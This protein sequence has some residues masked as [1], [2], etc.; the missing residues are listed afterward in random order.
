MRVIELDKAAEQI[1]R[2]CTPGRRPPFFFIIGAGISN[3][4]I[5]LASEIEEDCRTIALGYDQEDNSGGMSAINRYSY[6]FD[7]AYEQPVL[8]QE[9]LR[10]LIEGTPISHA[11]FRLAHLLLEKQISNIV[12]TPNFDDFLS[13]ALM[14]FGKPHI[15]CD[16]P[17]TVERINPERDDIQILHVHGTYWFY[18]C[19]NLKDEIENRARTSEQTNETMAFKLDDI[20]SRRSPLVIGYSGWEGDVIMSALKR[21]LQTD[22]PYNLYWFCYKTEAV[23]SLPEWLRSH[24]RVCLVTSQ[25]HSSSRP[26]SEES[27][28]LRNRLDDAQRLYQ[29]ALEVAPRVRGSKK[30]GSGERP[31]T[32]P[33]SEAGDLPETKPAE[34]GLSAER[35]LD[36]LIQSFN[37]RAPTLTSDP[38]G[39]FANYLHDLL[40]QDNTEKATGSVYSFGSVVARIERAKQTENIQTNEIELEKVRDALR[41]SQYREAIEQ[42]A[43]ISLDGLEQR[44]LSELMAAMNTAVE[45]STGELLGYDLIIRIGDALINHDDDPALHEQL[46]AQMG[47]ALV[48]KG[49][50]LGILNRNK[51]AIALY[52]EF[53]RRF[54]E[55]PDPALSDRVALALGNKAYTLAVLNQNEAA[56]AVCEEVVTRFGKAETSFLREQVAAALVRKGYNLG[57][58][59]RH[60]A[61]IA[62]CDECLM[63]FANA[64]EPGLTQLVAMASVNKSYRL[65]DLNRNEEA[66]A[67]CDQV[68]TR[69]GEASESLLREQ[70]ARALISKAETLYTLERIEE[71]IAVCDEVVRRF[72]EAKEPALR[73]HLALALRDKI[74]R[75]VILNRRQEANDACDEIVK[76]FGKT[77]EPPLIERVT[78]ALTSV[79]FDT[80]C[81]AKENYLKGDRDIGHLNLLNARQRIEAAVKLRP[82]YAIALGNKGYIEFLLGEKDLAREILTRAIGLGGKELQKGELDDSHIHE[83]PEDEEFRQMVLSIPLPEQD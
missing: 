49:Y 70:V 58:L 45:N 28:D 71:A 42:G 17:K 7:R 77:S 36:R 39:F 31:P 15:V 12:V 61:A 29:Q 5:P 33:Q 27:K 48:Q 30:S 40:P 80:L 50:T 83:L 57:V 4:P 55:A 74:Y 19:C 56:I 64:T 79:G 82:E 6:W 69:F 34:P 21:R 78:S 59:N 13:R 63:R 2:A 52:D 51:E 3:P 14:L 53:L 43:T 62:E 54:S 26:E 10:E 11:N 76:R 32:S 8:R 47:K 38:L 73:E 41:R 75:L 24:P 68:V 18:D 44:Q 20:L 65:S 22:L 81:Q 37:L 35:V 46:R 16:H 1:R 60:E 67:V 72:G 25:A 9:Y 66:I 23:D